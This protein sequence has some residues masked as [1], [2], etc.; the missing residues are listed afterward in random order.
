[1]NDSGAY[2]PGFNEDIPKQPEWSYQKYW[3]AVQFDCADLS[4]TAFDGSGLVGAIFGRADVKGANFQRAVLSR[5][6]FSQVANLDQANFENACADTAPT[7]P[8]GFVCDLRKCNDPLKDKSPVCH[9]EDASAVRSNK[10][11][12]QSS[13]HR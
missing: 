9:F 10:A 5:A 2:G 3:Y 8:A 1:M 12:C 6:D 13:F 7:F 11:A 4:G